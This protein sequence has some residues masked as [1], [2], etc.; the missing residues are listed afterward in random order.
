MRQMDSDRGFTYVELLVVIAIIGILAGLLLTS[1]GMARA[2]VGRATCI[3]N[4][5]QINL[6]TRMYADDHQ[7]AIVLPAGPAGP[8][9]DYQIYKEYVKSYAGYQGKPSANEKFFACPADRFYYS[10]GGGRGKL[11][12]KGFC[13]EPFTDF[14]SYAFN[15]ANRS[16]TNFAGIAGRHLV[17]VRRPARTLLILEAAA[18]TPFSWHRPQKAVGDYRF[19]DSQNVVSYVDGHVDVVKMY[20]DLNSAA[21][22]WQNDPPS[23]YD[24]Q[25]SGN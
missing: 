14:T 18:L 22:A 3:S 9:T 25:W 15:G 6:A 5:R 2:R 21:E 12:D 13:E 19:P 16:G 8:I 10:W 24:Y 11:H 17:S 23:G 4:L 7:D 20:V 1:L